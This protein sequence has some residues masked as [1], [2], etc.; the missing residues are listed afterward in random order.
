MFNAKSVGKFFGSSAK[1]V[2]D[3]TVNVGKGTASG[4][5]DFWSGIVAGYT[6]DESLE[7]SNAK[8]EQA[9]KDVEEADKASAKKATDRP[10]HRKVQRRTATA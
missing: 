10:L 5:Q 3:T 9:I 4:A 8:A 2:V 1:L 6:E 7:E